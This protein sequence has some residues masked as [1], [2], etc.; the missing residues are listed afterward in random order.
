MTTSLS[1]PAPQLDRAR[2]AHLDAALP[3]PVAAWVRSVLPEPVLVATAPQTGMAKA[4]ERV[5]HHL[6]DRDAR[7]WYLK[8]ESRTS[9]WVREV[10]AYRRWATAMGGL[11]PEMPF[12]DR[13]L[14]A[15]LLTALPGK[16][17]DGSVLEHHRVAGSWLALFQSAEEPRVRNASFREGRTI[18]RLRRRYPSL[19]PDREF[20]VARGAVAIL[21]ERPELEPVKVPS[22]GDFRPGNW[23]VDDAGQLRVIDLGSAGRHPHTRDLAA[24]SYGAW[25]RTPGA[26]EAFLEG[27]GRQLTHEEELAVFARNCEQA[28]RDIYRGHLLGV[29]PRL[30]RGRHRLQT[31]V[32]VAR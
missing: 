29:R 26:R 28:L 22:H 12:A 24:L 15:M 13:D 2:P 16:P 9:A 17:S 30:L 11:M 19:V 18:D 14:R 1:A 4:R 3:A 32:H 20:D 23:L 25:Q 5:V 10:R 31:L 21:E 27:F 8:L 7:E 6:V